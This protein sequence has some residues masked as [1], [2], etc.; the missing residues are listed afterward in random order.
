MNTNN[1]I[2]IPQMEQKVEVVLTC[3]LDNPDNVA[4]T[5]KLGCQLIALLDM[6]GESDIQYAIFGDK[7]LFARIVTRMDFTF[8]TLPLN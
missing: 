2:V 6:A 3:Q 8:Q 7:V 1:G 5:I 4:K